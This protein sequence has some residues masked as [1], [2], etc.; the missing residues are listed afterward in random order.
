MGAVTVISLVRLLPEAVNCW[1]LGVAD[2]VP[3][4]VEL[5]PVTPLAI[6]AGGGGN[7]LEASVADDVKN[8]N[9]IL[10]RGNNLF[11]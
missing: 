2:G 6:I 3:E 1:I 9:M 10:I 4:Q 5:F 11:I 8:N 7:F